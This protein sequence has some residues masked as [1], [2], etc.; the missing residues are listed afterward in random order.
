MAGQ[1]QALAAITKS[2]PAQPGGA[3]ENRGPPEERTVLGHNGSTVAMVKRGHQ[4]EMRYSGVRP[5]LSVTEGTLLFRGTVTDRGRLEGTAY[6]FKSGCTPADYKVSGQQ[7]NRQIVLMGPA[8]VRDPH[9]CDILR[10]DAA[11]GSGT[12]VFDIAE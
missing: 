7:T 6:T 8:P 3:A 2:A 4:V 10:Y 9:S 1:L 11:A 5:G 12:L